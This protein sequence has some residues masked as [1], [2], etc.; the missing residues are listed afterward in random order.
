MHSDGVGMHGCERARLWTVLPRADACA[1]CMRAH[2][3]RLHVRGHAATAL[4]ALNLAC[5][6]GHAATTMGL[7]PTLHAFKGPCSGHH[8]PVSDLACIQGA[9]Q[10]PPWPTAAARPCVPPVCPAMPAVTFGSQPP[11]CRCSCA[12]DT[13]MHVKGC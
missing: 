4:P 6:L 8:G 12:H 7:C 9:M 5:I 2:G 3:L 11:P 10:R 13:S 1:M